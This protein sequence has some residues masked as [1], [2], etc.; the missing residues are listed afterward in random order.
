[1]NRLRNNFI[2][3][4]YMREMKEWNAIIRQWNFLGNTIILDSPMT[5]VSHDISTYRS[6]VQRKGTTT[7]NITTY[8][9][10]FIRPRVKK[11]NLNNGFQ[12]SQNAKDTSQCNF[13][14]RKIW[15]CIASRTDVRF[16]MNSSE[17]D[18]PLSMK[19]IVLLLLWCGILENIFLFT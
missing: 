9:Q 5:D 3:E 7:T 14:A 18:S 10:P 6:S 8:T 12:T 19:R 1:M 16:L 11:M 4:W 2:N 17:K 13:Y 15:T